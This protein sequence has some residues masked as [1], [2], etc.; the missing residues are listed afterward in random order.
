MN[1]RRQTALY[2]F[3][4]YISAFIVWFL[5]NVLRYEV[6]AI[7]EGASSLLIYLQYP[8]VIAGQ[9][10]IPFF[11]LILYYLSGYYNKPIGKSRLHELFLTCITTLI[12]TLI[13]FFVLV[14]DD[15]PQSFNVYYQLFFGL[16]GMQFVLTYIPRLC[17]TQAGIRNIRSRKWSIPVLIIG[18]GPKAAKLAQNLYDLGSDIA[19]FI[20]ENEDAVVAVDPDT[21]LGSV[22]DIPKVI[23]S[24]RVNELVLAV[25]SADNQ[26]LISLLYSLYPYKMPIR[27]LADRMGLLSRVRIKT[28]VGVPLVDM[29]DNN[30]SPAAQNIKFCLDKIGA[31]LALLLLSP[32][33]LYLSRR[34]RRD[35]EGPVFFKQERI[36]RFGK[37]FMMYKF[38]TMYPDAESDGP[39]LSS[40]QDPRITPFGRILRKYRIDELPQFWNVLRGDMSLVGPR[41]ERKCFIDQIIKQAP[42][43]YLLHNVRPGITS[44]GMVKYGYADNVDKMVERLE[45]DILYYENMSLTMDLTILI[46]TVQTVITG[47]GI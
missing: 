3:S 4:D 27:I 45:Y 17:I 31:G 33:F 13:V 7:Y 40:E 12:G 1:K 20:R 18:T 30:F 46:Y 38:R 15:L 41:P 25:E 6:F 10:L 44:L 2:I 21:V 37:P 28:I 36:G 22:A 8:N 34:I 32:L 9:V 5:F 23:R 29:T 14:L 42:Y 26:Q 24:H 39:M 35:S 43:Y 16:F 11:W 47:K 19:G